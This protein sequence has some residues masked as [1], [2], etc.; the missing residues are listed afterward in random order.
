MPERVTIVGRTPFA[1]TIKAIKKLRIH[2]GCAIGP[3]QNALDRVSLGER[4]DI[5]VPSVEDRDAL[6][7]SLAS[8]GWSTEA[9]PLRREGQPPDPP[10]W[11]LRVTGRAR[12]V[13]HVE[14]ERG[15]QLRLGLRDC[16]IEQ[17]DQIG[18]VINDDCAMTIGVVS[19]STE[20]DS[21]L[22][23]PFEEDTDEVK[24]FYAVGDDLSVFANEQPMMVIRWRLVRESLWNALSHLPTR[25]SDNPEGGSLHRYREYLEH[26][27]LGLAYDELLGLAEVNPATQGFHE[28]MGEA[29]RRLNSSGGGVP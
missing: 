28:A 23:E 10:S 21:V 18:L 19:M 13:G 7:D 15:L 20:Q 17:H 4:V 25:L 27:E 5:H 1:K 24:Q 26:N 12:I 3:A 14:G 29:A 8:L 9:G 16:R 22:G 2:T 11:W 6:M